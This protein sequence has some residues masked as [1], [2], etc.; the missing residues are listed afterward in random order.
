MRV[1]IVTLL[2]GVFDKIFDESVLGSAIRNGLIEIVV[3]QLREYGDGRHRTVDDTPFG[4]GPGMVLKPAP[5]VACLR[6]VRRLGSSAPV[7]GLTPQGLP[8]DQT[9]VKELAGFERIILVCGRYEGFDERIVHE[10]DLQLSI[11]DYVLTGGEIAAMA[12]VDAVS[13]MIPG[14]VGSHESVE[15]DSFYEGLLDHPQYTRPAAW[16]GLKVPKVLQDG[17]HAHIEKFRHCRSLLTT[18]VSR[19]DVFAAANL[20]EKDREALQS[21]LLSEQKN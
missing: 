11:G 3:H 2:P 21:L 13:R 18:A 17:N 5:L 4:G 7:I 14:T 10:F 6:D 20:S 19:P 12:V 15:Q 9:L 16:E 8:L 1:D